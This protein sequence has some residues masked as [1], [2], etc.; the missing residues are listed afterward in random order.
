MASP[1]RKA[2]AL[3]SVS[4]PYNGAHAI[5]PCD[6]LFV[7]GERTF[8]MGE[9][10]TRRWMEL[11]IIDGSGATVFHSY[12][13][14]GIPV[15][16]RFAKKGLTDEVLMRAPSFDSQWLLIREL[17]KC[18]HVVGWWMDMERSFFPEQLD[19]C[20]QLHCAQARF[21]PLVGD[22]SMQYANYKN[23][24]MWD[25]FDLLGLEQPTGHRHR[26]MTDVSAMRLIWN[27]LEKTQTQ[28]LLA[29]SKKSD[30]YI[31]F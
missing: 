14:P 31:P 5:D 2:G 20:K 12:F 22:Y 25:A 13:N 24:G 7:D 1:T 23:I 17:V 15:D 10:G 28:N 29:I 11:A 19:F 9:C 18:K 4:Y 30:P 6:L 8:P 26:A 21:S 27:W 3:M 16:N